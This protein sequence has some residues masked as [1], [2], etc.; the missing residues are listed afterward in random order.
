MAFGIIRKMDKLD[1]IVVP[2]ETCREPRLRAGSKV[3]ID[4]VPGGIVLR[5]VYAVCAHCGATDDLIVDGDSAICQSCL[6]RYNR[7]AAE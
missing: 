6:D 3:Q 7:K 1:R 5:P 2:K 4:S